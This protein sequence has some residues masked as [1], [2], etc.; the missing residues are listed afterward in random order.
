MTGYGVCI[1][2]ALDGLFAFM[3]DEQR[4]TDRCM[5]KPV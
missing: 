1:S 3:F 2:M 5:F 4:E